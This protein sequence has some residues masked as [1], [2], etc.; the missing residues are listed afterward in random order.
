MNAA[1]LLEGVN[2]DALAAVRPEPPCKHDKFFDAAVYCQRM[3]DNYARLTSRIT[4]KRHLDVGAGFGYL[5]IALEAAGCETTSL[6]VPNEC[7]QRVAPIIGGRRVWW[8]LKAGE[9][10]P[11]DLVGFDSITMLGVAPMLRD[12]NNGTPWMVNQYAFLAADQ[13]K[14]L[15]PGG[16][17]M[18]LI[19]HVHDSEPHHVLRARLFDRKWW[20]SLG[21]EPEIDDPYVY[22][23]AQP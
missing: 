22:A 3:L 16:L 19:N 10:L 14:R 23:R 21:V 6:D 2:L 17:L 8:R 4:P 15:R 7:L 5:A 9:P 18:W 1:Q 13:L 20:R 11:D 12:V